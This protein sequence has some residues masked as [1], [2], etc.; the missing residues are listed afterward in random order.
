MPAA[1]G[2]ALPIS[3]GCLSRDSHE[4]PVPGSTMRTDTGQIVHL[5]DYRPTDFVLERV[6]LTFELDP[7]NTKVEARLI[8][9]RREGVDPTAPLVLDGD[10]LTLSGLLLD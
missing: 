2:T 8:F 1:T 7:T 5:A 3:V 10:E 9:H 6:D 4:E